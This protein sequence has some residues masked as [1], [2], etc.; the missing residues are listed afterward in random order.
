M[1]LGPIFQIHYKTRPP[2]HS[3]LIDR[4][5][6]WLGQTPQCQYRSNVTIVSPRKITIGATFVEGNGGK[7]RERDCSVFKRWKS[8][9][10]A[11]LWGYQ[12][13]SVVMQHMSFLKRIMHV[14]K[15]QAISQKR[16]LHKRS[17]RW[18]TILICIDRNHPSVV[19][20]VLSNEWLIDVGRPGRVAENDQVRTSGPL[21]TFK[22]N[23]FPAT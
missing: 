23:I 14:K 21:G 15:L 5:I 9:S 3:P 12:I 22:F 7:S 4:M 16:E 6:D 1:R 8:A 19:A 20:L 11:A 2:Y 18:P 13:D 17:V 10:D